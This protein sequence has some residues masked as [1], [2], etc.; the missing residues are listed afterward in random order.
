MPHIDHCTT[1]TDPS[2]EP[3][4]SLRAV[5]VSACAT[6][7]ALLAVAG[8][9]AV[10]SPDSRTIDMS[11]PRVAGL[12]DVTRAEPAPQ[13]EPSRTPNRTTRQAPAGSAPAGGYLLPEQGTSRSAGRV[14][15]DAA[16]VEQAAADRSAI[17]ASDAASIRAAAT[18]ANVE[19]RTEA[20]DV[21]VQRVKAE[22]VRIAEQKRQAELRLPAERARQ[23]AA[24]TAAATAARAPQ[25]T[26]DTSAP[27]AAAPQAAAQTP[28]APLRG[29]ATQP[30]A[31]DSYS[32]G[33]YWGKVGSWS[34]WHTG[35]DLPAPVGTPVR[36][37][38]DGIVSIDCAG[39]QGWA[40]DSV[41]VIHHGDGTSTLYAHMDSRTV[42][43]GQVVA[44]GTT[45]GHVGMK[46]RTF[47]AHLHFEHYPVGTTPGDVY[48]TDNPVAWLL[49]LG[50]HV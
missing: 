35:Q 43:A 30:M 18:A 21:D 27:A 17:L 5:G 28:A 3:T 40:G 26:D 20:L 46:G 42:S 6:S 48:S 13:A 23:E 19:T 9:L 38:A 37:V 34:R 24:R 16:V 32:V 15:L 36:A 12:V 39:C 2:P 11:G 7:L 49:G 44:A 29:G 45:I 31:P 1:T 10:A 50:V 8:A 22:Q 41:V 25:A 47:G 4:R 33:A 14:A